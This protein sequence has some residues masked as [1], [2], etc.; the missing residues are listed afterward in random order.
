LDLARKHVL[1]ICGFSERTRWA[2][3]SGRELCAQL[4]EGP[5]RPPNEAL[6]LLYQPSSLRDDGDEVAHNADKEELAMA[7]SQ[8]HG[9]DRKALEALFEFIFEERFYSR[10]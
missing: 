6:S 3:V 1:K 8:Y 10:I 7:I 9:Q 2:Q 4:P 5:F